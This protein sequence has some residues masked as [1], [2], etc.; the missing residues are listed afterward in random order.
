MPTATFRMW[1]LGLV[2]AFLDGFATLGAG[3]LA[4]ALMAMKAAP[5]AFSHEAKMTMGV[6]ILFASLASGLTSVRRYFQRSPLEGVW[7]GVTA[8]TVTGDVIVESQQPQPD[9][10]ED[11]NESAQR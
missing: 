4:A 10:T 1:G 11:P 9:T 6:G 7:P 3:L 8:N 5:G 2:A